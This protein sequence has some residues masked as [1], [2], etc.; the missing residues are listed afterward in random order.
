MMGQLLRPWTTKMCVTHFGLPL[1][2]A[3]GPTLLADD[4][5]GRVAEPALAFIVFWLIAFWMYR[6]KIFFR[7]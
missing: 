1:E 5:Y 2:L 3:F 7:V 6:R 4:M